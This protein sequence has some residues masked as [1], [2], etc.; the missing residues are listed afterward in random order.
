M[1]LRKIL[2]VASV[3]FACVAQAQDLTIHVNKKG[4][5]GFVDKNGAE[6]IKCAYESAYPF[7]GGYAIV[8]KSGKSGIIDERGKVVLPLKYTSYYALESVPLF[9]KDRQD[10]RI[11]KP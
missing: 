1:R 4:K 6:V 3:T 10:T 9:D 11:G 2:M 7:S 5:V 8:T